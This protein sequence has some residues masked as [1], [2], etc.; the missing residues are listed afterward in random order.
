MNVGGGQVQGWLKQIDAQRGLFVREAECA[1]GPRGTVV[2]LGWA[3]LSMQAAEGSGLNLSVS[4]LCAE[5]VQ[6]GWRVLYLRSGM[7]YSLRPGMRVELKEVWRGIGCFSLINSPNL[8]PGNFNFRN[9]SDQMSHGAQVE[10]VLSF[11]KATGAALVHVHAIEG[12]PLSLLAAAAQHA[13]VLVTPHN[14][15]F[16]CPQVD[17]LANE[18]EVCERFEGGKR[19]EG[20]LSHAPAVT[21][22]RNWRKRYQSA[23]RVF[24][25]HALL[26]VKQRVRHLGGWLGRLVSRSTTPVVPLETAAVARP[27]PLPARPAD[28][29][30]R[31]LR[32]A[33]EPSGCVNEYG[34]RR[35]RGIEALGAVHRVLCP[36][37]FLRDVH[38]AFG[39]P[40]SV[41]KHV[42]LGQPHFD[43][44]ARRAQR[45]LYYDAPA[46]TPQA[47]RP[48]RIAYFG[49]CYPN[50]GL[51]TLCAA[52]ESLA[53][54]IIAN[55][56]VVVRASGD[57][58]AFRSWMQE[59]GRGRVA[60]LGGYNIEDLLTAG[61]SYDICCFPNTGLENSP[62]VVL[63]SLH[64]GRPVIASRLGG[65]TDFIT[66]E[67]NGLL[68]P[69]ADVPALAAVFTR[70]LQGGWQLPTARQVHEASS[71]CSFAAYVDAVEAEY[72]AVGEEQRSL[73][74]NS[75]K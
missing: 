58:R 32:S 1:V 47:G 27:T 2:V 11:I 56:N 69:S 75:T 34:E 9:I 28:Q 29:N 30:E 35:R 61:D 38:G 21:G 26:E 17:L 54:D 59:R 57:D 39:V 62:F 72:S 24:G 51:A 49:N 14:Y 46:W 50:K 55:M 19:C 23:E 12:F 31:L 41:L 40:D 25:P 67:K 52:L 33:A 60:F 48:L 10:L 44:L 8:A 7:D 18:R 4:E 71:L 66:D 15:Y 5:L 70:L 63:E 45:S 68:F 13:G 36:S 42:A 65:P 20:C 73:R 53:D 64:C 43:E 6:R 16:V 74:A 22:Y 37:R 3:R